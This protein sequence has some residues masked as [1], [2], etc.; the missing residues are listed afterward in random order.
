[1]KQIH[2]EITRE[3]DDD[4]YVYF[5]T[6]ARNG[7]TGSGWA[8]NSEDAAKNAISNLHEKENKILTPNSP[9]WENSVESF[10][11]RSEALFV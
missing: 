3:I 11:A 1:M 5:A 2:I 6:A 9:N 10:L 4:V 8:L 7:V